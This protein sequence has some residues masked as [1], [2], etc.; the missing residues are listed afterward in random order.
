[1]NPW[2]GLKE[3]PHNIWILAFAT[4]INRSGTMVLPFLA[5]YMAKDFG[6]SAGSAGLVIAFYGLGAL[7][8]AP[9]VG[10]LSDK[11][12]ALRV[13]K[14]SLIFTGLMLFVYPFI[15]DYYLILGYTVIWSVISE[16][17]RPANL[18]LISTESEPAKR[19]TSFALN[20]LAINLG[21]SIGPVVGG[22]L[23]T[24]DFKLLFYVDGIT[25][26]AAGIFLMIARFNPHEEQLKSGESVSENPDK[27]L[28]ENET[29]INQQASDIR[30]Q[31]SIFKDKLF[32]VFLFSLIPVNIVFFQHIGGLPLYIVRDLGYSGAIFGLLSA[33]NTV[34]IIFVEVPLNNAMAGWD[35]RKAMAL[36][37]ILC[38]LGFGMMV[39]WQNIFFI[40][41]T[42]LIWTF[43]E[44]IFFPA[45]TSY[46]SALSPEKRR[47]EYMGYFQMTFS[48]ALMLGPWLGTEVLDLFGSEILWIGTFVFSSISALLFFF[49]KEKRI[50]VV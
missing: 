26:V 34:T 12:G 31:E 1:M 2:R 32:L 14:L 43:G 37:A 42:I 6:V 41:F 48:L 16:A 40:A 21:M 38:G 36:G 45:S 35:D 15:T 27:V 18:S 49:F 13:M 9:I 46:T 47:G 11:L 24:I 25:S 7:F 17:F 5:L 39:F 50:P 8:T 19:K 30:N 44:M 22:I 3:I 23:T 28:L 4:L 10:K 29:E 33:I 20:R